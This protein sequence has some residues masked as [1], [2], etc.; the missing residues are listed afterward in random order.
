MVRE[1]NIECSGI[2][3]ALAV[4]LPFKFHIIMVIFCFLYID[5]AKITDNV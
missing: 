1:K 5:R 3:F 2:I 4:L